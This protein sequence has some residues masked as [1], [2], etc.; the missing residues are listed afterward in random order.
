MLKINFF[1]DS[2]KRDISS[3]VKEYEN[4]W[5]EFGE[6]IVEA[7]EKYSG[8]KFN[9]TYVNALVFGAGN[10]SQSHP[11]CLKANCETDEKKSLLLHELAHRI[12]YRKRKLPNIEDNKDSTLLHFHMNLFLFD[13]WKEV[14]GNEFA[15]QSIEREKLYAEKYKTAWEKF[16]QHTEDERKQILKEI[17][18]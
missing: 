3:H 5:N 15:L 7:F 14:F 6:K 16:E 8:L 10:L 1:P 2:D 4:I 11:L 9:E 12:I 13:V 18:L 17:L